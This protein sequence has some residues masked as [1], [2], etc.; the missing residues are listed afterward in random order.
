MKAEQ[1]PRYPVYVPKVS[2]TW[3]LRT[4]PNRRFA[5]REITSMFA[6]G[7]SVLM[8]AFLFSLS[9]GRQTY[10]G[11]L[12]WL[13]GPWAVAVSVVILAAVLYHTAT[14]FRLTTHI[15]EVRLGRRVLPRAAVGGALV[16]AWIVASAVVA[17]FHV[18]FWR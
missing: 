3:W 17:Y 14:W 13:D 16:A 18:W 1:P 11:F 9:R 12:R 10:E 6:A 7:F 4:G 5:A 2:R 15:V 8:L